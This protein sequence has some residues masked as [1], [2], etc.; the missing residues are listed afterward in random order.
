MN[1]LGDLLAQGKTD[2]VWQRCCGFIDLSLDEFMKIQKRLLIEQIELLKRCELGNYIMRGIK[3]ATVEEFRETVPLTTYKDYAPYLLRRRKDVLPGKPLTWIHT[4]GRSGEYPFKWVPVTKRQYE[5][6]G[7]PFYSTLIFGSCRD[8]GDVRLKKNDK[9][10]YALA[11]S[12]YLTGMGGRRIHEEGIIEFLPPIDEAEGMEFADRIQEGFRLALLEGMEWFGGLSSV[13]VAVAD[14]FSQGDGNIDVK[15][16]L[17]RPR[18]LLRLVKG[19]L[20]SKLARRPLLP[21]DIW[22]IKGILASGTDTQVF[23]DKIKDKW[24]VNP[25]EAY[26]CTEGLLIAIQTWDFRGMT[27][28]P[29]LNFLEFIPEEDSRKSREDPSMK[30]RVLLLDEVEANH[31][32]EMV[33]TN[34]YGGALTRYRLGDLIQI[35]ELRNDRLDIDIPQM[36]FHARG[37]DIIDIA[38][39]TRLTERVIWKAIENSELAYSDWTLRKEE[40]KGKTTMHLYI[41]LKNGYFAPEYVRRCIHEELKK[42]DQPYAELES[43]VAIDPLQ[44]TL[45][46]QGVFQNYM[47]KQKEAGADLAHLKIPHIN[48]SGKMIEFLLATGKVTV[49]PVSRRGR[50]RSRV[51]TGS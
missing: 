29:N 12:P 10:L 5:E 19:L 2:E 39:F 8:R 3:P 21:R 43:F 23:R 31:N 45:L 16:L 42:L 7:D 28:I 18:T 49:A 46:P 6:M 27:F 24:G 25:V 34:F 9:L 11:P 50:Q 38:G 35:T 48:P 13:L 32:Y 26:G 33:I 14:R 41:E 20:R 22:K 1:R 40:V 17:R 36:E 51:P 4:S 30:P 44:V 37:D 15:P 47:L